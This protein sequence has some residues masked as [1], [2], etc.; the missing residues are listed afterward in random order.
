[1]A[2][3]TTTSSTPQQTGPR[4]STNGHSN[5]IGNEN[6]SGGPAP[7]GPKG[8]APSGGMTS[9]K[10]LL[11]G[12]IAA[13]VL[14]VGGI[15]GMRFLQYSRTHVSTDDAF[16]TGNLVNVSATVSG[17]LSQLNVSEG[18]VVKR[19]QLLARLEE[20]GPRAALQQAEAAYQAALSQIP[21]ARSSL[22][23][24]QQATDAAIRRAQA[25]LTSQQAKTRGANAQ[26]SLAS[27]TTR[28]QIAQARAQISAAQAEAAQADAQ[29]RSAEA[30]VRA[31]QQAV[32]TADRGVAS[33]QARISAAQAEVKRTQADLARYTRLLAQEAVTQQQFDSVA[34]QAANA[35]SAL[36]SLTEQVAQARS[37]S[38]QAQDNVRQGQA[39]VAAARQGAQAAREQVNVARAGLGVAQANQGQVAVQA[40]NLA[41]S[42]A[43]DIQS[44]ADIQN[45]L[46]GRTQV[47]LSEQRIQT[48]LSQAQQAKAALDNARVLYNKTFIYA[49]TDGTVVR[50]TINVGAAVSPGQTIA[51]MTQGETIWV[52][53]NFKETQLTNV[54]VGQPV[55]LEVDAFP[56]K[57]FKGIVASVSEATGATTSLLPPDNATGNFT[58]VVQRVPVKIAIVPE[59][60]DEESASAE[61]I[62]RLRQGM[63]VAATVETTDK[64]D[65]PD[66]VPANYDGHSRG[67]SLNTGQGGA[68]GDGSDSAG[69]GLNTGSAQG[70]ADASQDPTGAP[71][72]APPSVGESGTS[73]IDTAA[74][75]GSGV[76]A[77]N[78]ASQSSDTSTAAPTVPQ[79]NVGPQQ[80]G[81]QPA[82]NVPG[83]I[84]PGA[85]NADTADTGTSGVGTGAGAGTGNGQ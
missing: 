29:I 54:R 68:Q 73:A 6:G 26:V 2:E 53:A 41:S 35:Q 32:K 72:Q 18:D 62:A 65:H 17:T 61:D 80:A 52:T 24:Q 36:D 8:A 82:P 49:P 51:T 75:A 50:K 45:A 33:L 79:P 42:A 15:W 69:S 20:N 34:S 30:A 40:G 28:N 39:Q 5:G 81:Q 3:E 76:G 85:N 56:G 78:S 21:Q 48:A 77:G 1:M 63:S 13:V 10:K 19:G 38:Q 55:S 47:T 58:K 7:D 44:Q 66:R 64:E 37:Q 46:A 11:F 16:V 67:E 74:G 60:D 43:G 14:L 27:G 9:G 83:Q 57:E 70:N 31:Y 84:A 59:E 25:A 22:R 12:V 23:F 71:A 4:P